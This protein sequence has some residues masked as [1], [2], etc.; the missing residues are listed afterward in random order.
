MT[1]I[2]MSARLCHCLCT[3]DAHEY[4]DMIKIDYVLATTDHIPFFMMLNTGSLPVLLPVDNGSGVGR[5]EWSKLSKRELNDYIN[6]S[7]AL[8]GNIEI[9]K[10]AL[11]CQDMNCKN[12]QHCKELCSLYEAIVESL[13]VSSRPLHRHRTKVCSAKPVWNDHVEEL[14]AEA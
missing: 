2:L 3:V 8:L 7:D 12:V 4:I 14:H 1:V 9:P 11:L 6:H 13:G 10:D 5:I